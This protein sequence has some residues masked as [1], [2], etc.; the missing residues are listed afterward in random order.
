MSNV[1]RENGGEV[2]AVM[3]TAA[4]AV[5]AIWAMI[6]FAASCLLEVAR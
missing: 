3:L 2:V 4:G 1:T 6:G 5:L